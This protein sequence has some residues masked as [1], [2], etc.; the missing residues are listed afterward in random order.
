MKRTK[1]LFLLQSGVAG[2][3]RVTVTIAKFL[4]KTKYDLTFALLTRPNDGQPIRNFI[5]SDSKIISI[6]NKGGMS[7][8]FRLIKCVKQENPQIV[9][10]SM[11]FINT[12]VLAASFLFPKIKFIVRNNNYLYT[13][14]K[15]QKAILN[16]T[17]RLADKV[18]AQT[19]EMRDELI[20]LGLKQDRVITLH[21]HIDTDCIDSKQNEDSPFNVQGSKIYVASGRFHEVKGFD[22]LIDA[23]NIL[24]RDEPNSLLYIIGKNCDNCKGYYDTI[25]KKIKELKIEEKVNCVGFQDNPYKYVKNADC[26]VLSSRNEG[27]PNVLIES[28]YMGTPVASTT[29]IPIIE[30]IVE[31]GKT[32]YLADVNDAMSLSDAMKK[33]SKLG[34]IVSTYK[35]ADKDS[36]VKI[37]SYD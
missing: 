11:M 10:S 19:E 16:F 33:S 9:F 18:I 8:L 35:S 20:S 32:G 34:R 24:L 15:S 5:P 12:K 28:L 21:N 7:L 4:D 27:L 17:Y 6:E 29:C 2:A 25:V 22:V 31:E 14:S 37:F 26:F 30:R 13:L 36:F 23:F 3:E 1:V